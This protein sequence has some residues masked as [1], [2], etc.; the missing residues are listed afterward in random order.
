M[1]YKKTIR[2][3]NNQTKGIGI[4]KQIRIFQNSIVKLQ[5]ELTLE[6]TLESTLFSHVTSTTRRTRR[7]RT[8]PN[9]T[10]QEGSIGLYLRE[11][12]K[13]GVRNVSGGCLEG[14]WKVSGRCLGGV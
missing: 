5:L 10:L 14:V 6:S 12:E 8:S 1:C 13:V 3:R 4:I 9:F 7:T 2:N 11:G